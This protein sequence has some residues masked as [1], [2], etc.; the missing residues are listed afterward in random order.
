MTTGV[1]LNKDEKECFD[2]Y[3]RNKEQNTYNQLVS[4][5]SQIRCPCNNILLRFDP[6]YA[7][8][9]FDRFNRVLCYA[10]MIVG[11]NAV[12]FYFINFEVYN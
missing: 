10:S 8:S 1:P 9:R 11:R 2:W 3:I 7:I 4:V 12:C 6:R 5:I